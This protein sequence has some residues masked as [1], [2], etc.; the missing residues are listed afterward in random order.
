MKLNP[1]EKKYVVAITSDLERHV[2]HSKSTIEKLAASF[3]ITNKNLVKELTELAIVNIARKL[4]HEPLPIEDRYHSI[5]ELYKHQVNLSHRTSE[6]IRLQQYST[7]APISYLAGVFCGI[8]NNNGHYFEPS[9]GN[10]LMTIAGKPSLFIV[11]EVDDIRR[12]NLLAQGFKE[13]L[14]QDA[15]KPFERFKNRFN[16]VLT[17][18]PFGS[19]PEPERIGSYWTKILDHKMAVV[20]LE[21]MKNTGKAAIII[22]GHTKWDA[23]GRIQKGKNRDF[24]LYLYRNYEVIDVI[25]IDGHKLYSRQGTA[26]DVRLILIDGRKTKPEG[27]PPIEKN[28]PKPVDTF[29]ELYDRV[30][31][32]VDEYDTIKTD[33]TTMF[34]NVKKIMPKHQQQLV[35]HD[36]EHREVIKRLEQEA[37]EVPEWG[38]T[39]EQ[40]KDKMIVYLHYFY[41]GSDWYILEWD[42]E[43]NLFFGYVIL[44]VDVMMSE[45]GTISIDELV[46]TPPVELDF[47][48]NKEQLAKILYRKDPDY[49]PVPKTTN[50]DDKKQKRIRVAKVKAAAKL[51]LLKLLEV[52][53]KSKPKHKR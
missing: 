13:V 43:N 11:N 38:S 4:A 40:T 35:F 36:P 48:W 7:P 9:A 14:N 31:K 23:K 25:N 39:A 50:E 20:A 12:H 22:G 47:Y 34:D 29:Q 2:K 44:N 15:S 21:T 37:K 30:I 16:A 18:P 49:F 33:Y 46:N 41:G 42:R 27:F 10:G 24:F 26:F 19:L 17:N 53:R 3:G 1:S 8:D 52:R 28:P 5:V 6:S 51:K 45:F 32:W